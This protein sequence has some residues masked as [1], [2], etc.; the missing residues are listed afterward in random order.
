MS[1][2]P[3]PVKCRRDAFDLFAAQVSLLAMPTALIRAAV[4]ISMHELGQASPVVVERQIQE[5]V[6]T[7]RR[8]VHSPDVRALV[9]HAHDVLFDELA[10]TGNRDNYYD[11]HNSYLP[12][13]M[14]TR[15]GIPITLT[16]IYLE[17]L[18]RLGV[19]AYGVNAPGHFLA[20]IDD[21]DSGDCVYID[22]FDTGRMLTR[23]EAFDRIQQ[24]MGRPVPQR[25]EL[26][27]A[28][29]REQLLAR[30]L[31]NLR[32]IFERARRADD[33]EAMDELS[34]LLVLAD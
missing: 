4:A 29:S 1:E 14:E 30:M 28:A 33:A 27:A 21:L 25:E 16:L 3:E 13:V 31:F 6:E 24:I 11:P 17:V 34:S 5:W 32:L 8:R 12:I 2:K 26:L 10:F 22:P 7:I 23:E 19:R 15:R 18:Q 9:A 20:A